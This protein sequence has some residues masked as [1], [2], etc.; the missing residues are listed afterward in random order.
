M[1]LSPFYFIE[2]EN[3][4]DLDLHF[5]SVYN[6]SYSLR[7]LEVD[8]DVS[9][10]FNNKSMSINMIQMNILFLCKKQMVV[11]KVRAISFVYT[12]VNL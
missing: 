5:E 7:F 4:I 2:K 8:I 6:L 1:G 11:L 9:I 3:N 10:L 12:F